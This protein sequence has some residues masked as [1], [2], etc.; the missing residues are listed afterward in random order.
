MIGLLIVAAIVLSLIKWPR[1]TIEEADE[2]IADSVAEEI[3]RPAGRHSA[4]DT[5]RGGN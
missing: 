5:I 2:A 1:R 4:D 3:K